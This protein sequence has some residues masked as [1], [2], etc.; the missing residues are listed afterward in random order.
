MILKRLI[1]ITFFGL[2]AV[3]LVLMV[4]PMIYWILT[5]ESYLKLPDRMQNFLG[6]HFDDYD[7]K[8]FRYMPF[9]EFTDKEYYFIGKKNALGLYKSLGWRY[10]NKQIAIREAQYLNHKHNTNDR[11]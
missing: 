10:K 6:L 3:S 8:K 11:D 2:W 5:G 7:G 4:F 9:N 1:L